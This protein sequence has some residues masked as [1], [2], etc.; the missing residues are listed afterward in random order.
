MFFFYFF[1]FYS[2]FFY[3]L[4]YHHQEMVR[5]E[6]TGHSALNNGHLLMS[7][8]NLF[9][10]YFGQTETKPTKNDKRS[11][12]RMVTILNMMNQFTV[13]DTGI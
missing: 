6:I 8:G 4:H 10:F 5:F 11:T 7:G 9:V 2:P 12:A 1:K 13:F 3:F